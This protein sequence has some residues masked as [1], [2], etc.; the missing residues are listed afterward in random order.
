MK[1]SQNYGLRLPRSPVP[2]AFGSGIAR[3]DG[4][5]GFN[6]FVLELSL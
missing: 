1:Q 2:K 6:A 5:K 4:V 3:N